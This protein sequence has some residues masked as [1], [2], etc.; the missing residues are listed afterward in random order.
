MGHERTGHTRSVCYNF[1]HLRVQRFLFFQ[2]FDF[3]HRVWEGQ[4]TNDIRGFRK[5]Q[6]DTWDITRRTRKY[7]VFHRIVC[8]S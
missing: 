4:K 6:C 2:T 5:D 3:A 8:D 7:V 1:G